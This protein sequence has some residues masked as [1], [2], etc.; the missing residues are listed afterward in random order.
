MEVGSCLLAPIVKV[1]WQLHS[2]VSSVIAVHVQNRLMLAHDLNYVN[3]ACLGLLCLSALA[4]NLS[5]WEK[6]AAGGARE[7]H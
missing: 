3:V 6:Q 1:A 7:T 5:Q 2:F 4:P